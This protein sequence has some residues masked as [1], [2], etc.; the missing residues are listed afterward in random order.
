MKILIVDDSRAMRL[1][2]RGLLK[3]AISGEAEIL[4]AADGAAALQALASDPADLVLADWN[5]PGMSGIELLRQLRGQGMTMPFGLVTTEG[6]DQV[7]REAAAAGADFLLPKPFTASELAAALQVL[8]QH[9][10]RVR[11]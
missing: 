1:I 5:M 8:K 7:R 3:Q 2:L 11:G 6:T 10:D 9:V 4:E